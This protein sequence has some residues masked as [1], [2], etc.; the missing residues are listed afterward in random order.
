VSAPRD[1]L[2]CLG[3]ALRR[4]VH[5]S[6]RARRHRLFM[7]IVRP[8]AV[9]SVL[10][11]GATDLAGYGAN[12]LEALYPWP[13][14]I[15]AAAVEP[16]RAFPAAFPAVTAVQV[17]GRAL[18]FADG[19]FDIVHANAVVEHVGDAEAQVAFLAELRR[20]ARRVV[21]VATPSRSFVV[22]SHTLVPF[23]HWLPP[24]LR[25][26]VYEWLDVGDWVRGRLRLVGAGELERLAR[27]AGCPHP[28]VTR[29]RLLGM[30]SVLVLSSQ[31]ESAG[32]PHPGATSGAKP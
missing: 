10:D 5:A 21:F 26:R 16:R 9:D 1:R 25:D 14:R 11:V 31:L 17:D 19:A 15:T 30:T 29:Q 20:V 24:R 4:R 2:A 3:A 28:L 13:E 18:P 23:A 6:S 22:D 27:L 7:Q 12:T 32:R 8:T